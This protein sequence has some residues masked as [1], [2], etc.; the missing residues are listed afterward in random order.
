MF[1]IHNCSSLILL[2]AR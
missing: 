2:A 1:C